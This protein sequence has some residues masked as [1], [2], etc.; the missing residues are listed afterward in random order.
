MT[1]TNYILCRDDDDDDDDDDDGDGV[2]FVLG[3]HDEFAFHSAS[4]LKCQSASRHATPLGLIT[5]ISSISVHT[6]V[7]LCD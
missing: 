2:H 5:L 1:R 4:S 3:Q 6:S 7:V